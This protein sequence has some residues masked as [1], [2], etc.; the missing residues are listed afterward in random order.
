[1][2]GKVP[3]DAIDLRRQSLGTSLFTGELYCRLAA[4]LSRE[5]DFV[6]AKVKVTALQNLV[7]DSKPDRNS[8]SKE[9][10]FVSCFNMA[11]LPGLA[12][13]LFPE[14]PSQL[15]CKDCLLYHPAIVFIQGYQLPQCL[16]SLGH[17]FKINPLFYQRHMEYFLPSTPSRLFDTSVLPSD[18]LNI[19]R[20]RIVTIGD[21]GDNAWGSPSQIDNL[22]AMGQSDMV[23]Y[24]HRLCRQDG[25]EAGNSV[26]RAFNVHSAQYFS[27][28]Q[29]I[30]VIVQS[31]KS[32]GWALLVWT[33]FGDG[34]A[35]GPRGPWHPKTSGRRSEKMFLPHIRHFP[36][37]VMTGTVTANGTSSQ[38][39]ANSPSS[40]DQSGLL[41]A[42]GYGET[43][44]PALLK[45]DSFYAM[46][47][48]FHHSASS[49]CQLLNVIQSIIDDCTGYKLSKSPSHSLANLAYHLDILNRLENG[50]CENL[51]A[52]KGHESAKWPKNYKNSPDGEANAQAAINAKL[53][54][55]I[56]D[57]EK[58]ISRVESLSARCRGGMS[59]C[60]SSA[61]IE[62]SQRAIKQARQIELL[63]WF[64]FL[65]IPLSFTTSFFGMNVQSF[66]TGN[67]SL[68]VWF[69]VSIP[70]VAVSYLVLILARL[71]RVRAWFKVTFQG[72][73]GWIESTFGI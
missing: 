66:G 63:T 71:Q 67:V 36:I 14:G 13:Q 29:D 37:D 45:V 55:L 22:R 41:L 69:A 19:I 6:D 17:M 9:W 8:H 28:E 39:G 50:L 49:I 31:S 15:A 7:S 65:Y 72:V 46:S 70:L 59:I 44:D 64:A 58:L 52:L 60:M 62:E 43:L 53:D 1:M 16:K 48:L 18:T 20:L 27:I 4:F 3:Q 42:E 12:K 11:D 23:E 68:K 32:G 26:V 61:S 24:V 35:C 38:S 51:L 25:L 21:R 40:F 57:F 5:D 30:T 73:R 56:V 33:D 34:L 10:S 47:E 54:L 2:Y